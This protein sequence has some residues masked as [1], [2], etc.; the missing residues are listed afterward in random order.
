MTNI[1]ATTE[2]RQARKLNNSINE[3]F[4]WIYMMR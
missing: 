3:Y 1:A 2:D 4:I